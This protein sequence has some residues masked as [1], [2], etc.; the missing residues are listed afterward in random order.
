MNGIE[1]AQ[2]D[3]SDARCSLETAIDLINS[4]DTDGEYAGVSFNDLLQHLRQIKGELDT[5]YEQLIHLQQQLD[6]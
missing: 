2:F 1:S 6:S 5:S 3:L 4:I